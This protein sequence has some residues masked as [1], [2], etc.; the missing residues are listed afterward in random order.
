MPKKKTMTKKKSVKKVVKKNISKNK[1]I[2]KK[3][4]KLT[5]KEEV[6]SKKKNEKKEFDIKFPLLIVLIILLIVV[7]YINL[8]APSYTYIINRG[9]VT[10][11]SN[12][13]TPSESFNQLRQS[14]LVYVSPIL[15][16]SNASVFFT[17][18]MNL[19][20]VVLIGNNINPVQ[21][22]RVKTNNE[23]VYCYTNFGSVHDSNQI[24]IEACNE[25]LN[26]ESNFVV[27]INEGNKKVILDNNR[28]NVYS[29]EGDAAVHNFNI[30]K[31]VFPNAQNI[32]DAVNQRIYGIL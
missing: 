19:W 31:E 24:T 7:F 21:L 3:E 18:A 15:E 29:S 8:I 22:I 11:Y 32:L 26:D 30:L 14:D 2:A 12:T 5:K 27:F 20:Q 28:I 10:Y 6:V 16:E 9:G 4:N 1:E 17:N 23:L 25:I 13:L